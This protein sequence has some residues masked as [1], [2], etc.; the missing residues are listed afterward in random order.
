MVAVLM[1]FFSFFVVAIFSFILI[2]LVGVVMAP[3]TR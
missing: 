2:R 3:W 1:F